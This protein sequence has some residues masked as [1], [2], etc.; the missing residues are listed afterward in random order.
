MVLRRFFVQFSVETKV[1]RRPKG[2]SLL[3]ASGCVMMKNAHSR[4]CWLV[5]F[6]SD[7]VVG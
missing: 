2:V 1:Q 6:F 7:A 3:L 5:F 4:P